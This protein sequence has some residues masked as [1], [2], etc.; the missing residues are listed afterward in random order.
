MD[1]QQMYEACRTLGLPTD[2]SPTKE[3]IRKQYKLMALKWHPDKNPDPNAADYYR[4]IKEAHDYLL[5][6]HE[7]DD[8][9]D[10][11]ESEY[12]QTTYSTSYGTTAM[13]FFETLYS[14]PQFQRHVLHPLLT[15]LVGMCEENTLKFIS[16]LDVGRAEQ[17]VYVLETY[18]D[19]LHLSDGFLEVLRASIVKPMND[20]E[21][22]VLNPNLNDL[23]CCNV[24][25]MEME[26]GST[27][28]V[29]LWHVQT[30]LM[31]DDDLTIHCIPELP[32]NMWIDDSNALHIEVTE[33]LN[34]VW[35]NGCLEILVG[36][37]YSKTVD[38]SCLKIVKQQ[39]VTLPNSG[40]P[41]PIKNDI[42]NVENNGDIILHVNLL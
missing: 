38:A 40:L 39:T 6:I 35:E 25:K 15:K 26:D 31:F 20:C 17:I 11:C 22:I 8:S 28:L 2:P 3:E 34:N 32:D 12:C 29:P 37:R 27:I 9:M 14:D 42:Y 23:L 30:P 19:V 1:I 36:T 4:G 21:H 18:K 33:T 13:Q 16:S 7:S 10:T 24:Y 5:E 41:M